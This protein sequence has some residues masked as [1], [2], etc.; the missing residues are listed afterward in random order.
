MVN[1]ISYN[2][3]LDVRYQRDDLSVYVYD[4]T[5]MANFLLNDVQIKLNGLFS[6]SNQRSIEVP[7]P[8]TVNIEGTALL[9][10]NGSHFLQNC[11]LD[12]SKS[13]RN[14]ASTPLIPHDVIPKIALKCIE[15]K[16]CSQLGQITQDDHV[17]ARIHNHDFEENSA[18]YVALSEAYPYL[19]LPSPNQEKRVDLQMTLNLLAD[20]WLA[21]I[22]TKLSGERAGFVDLPAVSETIPGMLFISPGYFK[23]S[24]GT[25]GDF[26]T[27]RRVKDINITSKGIEFIAYGAFQLLQTEISGLCS[28]KY[29]KLNYNDRINVHIEKLQINLKISMNFN[30]KPCKVSLTS[31]N[32]GAG[33]ISFKLDKTGLLDNILTGTINKLINKFT[34]SLIYS[35]ESKLKSV[36][37]VIA[38]SAPPG[39]G[40]ASDVTTGKPS[41]LSIMPDDYPVT[42][43]VI[44]LSNQQLED[45]NC[46]SHLLGLLVDIQRPPS[47]SSAE[48]L[49]L[50]SNSVICEDTSDCNSVICLEEY[51]IEESDT[52]SDSVICLDTL[53]T[54]DC[55]SVTCLG[56]YPATDTDFNSVICLDNS[57]SES[58]LCL[59]QPVVS[60]FVQGFD[61]PFSPQDLEALS[62]WTYTPNRVCLVVFL[63]TKAVAMR[64]QM[65]HNNN[66]DYDDAFGWLAK[67]DHLIDE[68]VNV[69]FEPGLTPPI[70]S[71]PSFFDDFDFGPLLSPLHPSPGPL[72]VFPN[73][74]G[75]IPMMNLNALSVDQF[76]E[77]RDANGQVIYVMQQQQQSELICD[78]SLHQCCPYKK[79][80]HPVSSHPPSQGKQLKLVWDQL[81]DTQKAVID[82]ERQNR[83]ETTEKLTRKV[84][85]SELKV[86]E[87][88]QLNENVDND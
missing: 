46:Q 20:F 60:R 36:I 19:D 68:D 10:K 72:N 48:S 23:F 55:D 18:M 13:F 28:V 43:T 27:I 77:I 41:A 37:T 82:L 84:P 1:D 85:K 74:E 78:Q 31:L 61:T 24:N 63:E 54:W 6:N 76:V 15:S 32:M 47:P 42:V 49:D 51:Q 35:V 53:N 81:F 39:E 87:K 25:F 22:T 83:T 50:D 69:S 34:E 21:S 79:A 14:R 9:D 86:A 71:Q 44:Q 52:D 3:L 62:D 8:L 40:L 29:L 4:N 2:G 33:K 75:E 12:L 17:R 5:Q 57:D 26:K 59:D 80:V 66:S 11:K 56:E 88:K 38:S 70:P 67:V 73:L 16:L 64:K 58:V 45:I 7:S 30:K 65:N